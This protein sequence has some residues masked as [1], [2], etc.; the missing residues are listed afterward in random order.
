MRVSIKKLI[1]IVVLCF[2]FCPVAFADMRVCVEKNTGKLIE[3][4]SG[5]KTHPNPKINDAEYALKNLETLRQNAVKAGHKEKDI[6]VRVVTNTEYRIIVEANKP[7]PT[8]EQI[9]EEKIQIE[10]ERILREQAID[11]LKASGVIK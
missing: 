5:G 9:N 8:Q 2:V 6:E 11:N 10:M 7:I 3:S 1:G 4:Q